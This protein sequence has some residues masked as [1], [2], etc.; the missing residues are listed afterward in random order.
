M[1][2]FEVVLGILKNV[3]QVCDI[4]LSQEKVLITRHTTQK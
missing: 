1:E 3:I 4:S 2:K